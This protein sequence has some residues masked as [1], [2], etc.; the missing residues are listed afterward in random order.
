MLNIWFPCSGLFGWIVGLFLQGK[1]Q[2]TA[3]PIFYK[4]GIQYLRVKI[5][6]MTPNETM[7]DGTF[8]LTYSYRPTGGNP[9]SSQDIWGQAPVVSSVH[10]FMAEK[11]KLSTFCSRILSRKKIMVWPNLL[12]PLRARLAR[13]GGS[14]RKISYPWR[15]QVR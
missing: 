12:L 15:D 11:K 1:L 2:V 7:T 4:N 8:T 9:D 5:K 13:R 6:N 10:L 3:V 14:Y